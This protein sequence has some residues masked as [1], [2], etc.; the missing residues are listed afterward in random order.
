M[1]TFKNCIF[2]VLLL[3]SSCG[4]AAELSPKQKSLLQC[5]AQTAGCVISTAAA[6]FVALVHL[7]GMNKLGVAKYFYSAE[8]WHYIEHMFMAS[9]G[10]TCLC[11]ISYRLGKDARKS[12]RK[13]FCSKNSGNTTLDESSIDATQSTVTDDK[14]QQKEIAS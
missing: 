7:N 6:G 9:G 13:A 1:T 11:Y 4:V 10:V 12:Y 3:S 2:L 5:T 8:T 14:T